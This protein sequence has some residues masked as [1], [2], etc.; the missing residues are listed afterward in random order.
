MRGSASTPRGAAKTTRCRGTDFAKTTRCRG[1]DG[2]KLRPRSESSPP[3]ALPIV[4]EQRCLLLLP[5]PL[6][7]SAR[8]S[9]S[10]RLRPLIDIAGPSLHDHGRDGRRC[11]HNRSDVYTIT[12]L[13][14]NVNETGDAVSDAGGE[15][16]D[17]GTHTDTDTSVS[18]AEETCCGFSQREKKTQTGLPS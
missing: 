12:V 10:L 1:V 16:T 13:M 3:F 4:I 15:A 9:S 18:P 7:L 11:K 5:P 2:H 14:E 6:T 8:A 17:N